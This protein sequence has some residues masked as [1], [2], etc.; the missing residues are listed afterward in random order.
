MQRPGGRGRAHTQTPP[1]PNIPKPIPP[2]PSTL[3][4][5]FILVS[6]PFLLPTIQ[7]FPHKIKAVVPNMVWP[8]GVIVLHE[9]RNTPALCPSSGAPCAEINQFSTVFFFFQILLLFNVNIFN[10]YL[11]VQHR[12]LA[13]HVCT[14]HLSTLYV[15]FII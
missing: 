8:P 13:I 3:F 14:I 15:F 1:L 4:T 2:C 10:F 6:I 9:R 7:S 11:S 12:S 5:V